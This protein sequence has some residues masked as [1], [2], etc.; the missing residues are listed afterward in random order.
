[1]VDAERH[2]RSMEELSAQLAA[3]EQEVETVKRSSQ[4]ALEEVQ[5]QV[6][7]A[8][9]RLD[10]LRGLLKE[11]EATLCDDHNP[12]C[13]E[14]QLHYSQCDG[15]IA[16]GAHGAWAGRG[17][18]RPDRRR[19]AGTQGAQDDGIF[20]TSD[21][22]LD[23]SPQIAGP[24]GTE[25][26]GPSMKSS[27]LPEVRLPPWRPRFT[28]F[29]RVA[30]Q[31]EK[32]ERKLEQCEARAEEGRHGREAAEEEARIAAAA[33]EEARVDREE[34]RR[35]YSELIAETERLRAQVQKQEEQ[36]RHLRDAA[37][38]S[39]ANSDATAHGAAHGAPPVSRYSL[40]TQRGSGDSGDVPY[41]MF[42][43]ESATG[44]ATRSG[45]ACCVVQ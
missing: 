5:Q 29:T 37:D 7:E 40:W 27:A 12:P 1:M 3:K 4:A 31:M 24:G 21:V 41:T 13:G 28:W 43:E 19:L 25:G 23:P 32:L 14:R 16:G 6:V 17:P 18:H 2:P 38:H 39:T 33:A 35:A 9:A 10:E 26:T 11:R 22:S 20:S 44:D 42:E 36:I 30:A 34:A 15:S 45:P 8:F